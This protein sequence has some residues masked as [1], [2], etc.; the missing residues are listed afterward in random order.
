MEIEKFHRLPRE[1]P[2]PHAVCR[3]SER[4]IRAFVMMPNPSDR[5]WLGR[6]GK[7]DNGQV[8]VFG[9]LANRRFVS[10]VKKHRTKHVPKR[11]G[12][13]VTSI[14]DDDWSVLELRDTTR[15]KLRV[16]AWKQPV[17]VWD[18]SSSEVYRWHL[19]A[20]RTPGSYSDI[21]ISGLVPSSAIEV[22]VTPNK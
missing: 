14:P 16:V 9:A 15:G 21:K 6:L 20:T 2:E 8:A 7:V 22:L 13:I 10:P 1:M 11:V 12:E 5:Q 17:F 18:E 19:V 3:V 4:T